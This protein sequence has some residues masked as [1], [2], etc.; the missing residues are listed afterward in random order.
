MKSEDV[1]R[2]LYDDEQ[3]DDDDDDDDDD[4]SQLSI[5]SSS[6]S[7]LLDLPETPE[8][9]KASPT[10]LRPGVVHRLDKGTTGVLIAAKH[11]EA[12]SKLS[13]LFALRK[14]SKIYLAICVGHPG[15]ATIVEPIGRSM[16]NRQMM[17]V[18]SGP[19]GKLAVTHVRTI[20]F[21]GKK[22]A[23]LVRIETGRYVVI[24]YV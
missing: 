1:S 12:V 24:I 6:K 18:Y 7:L 11:S 13:R 20:A 5:D 23:C 2:N 10:Y 21:D 17:A 4:F 19:P 14:V 3:F 8:A 16:K 9:A 22:S 15:E